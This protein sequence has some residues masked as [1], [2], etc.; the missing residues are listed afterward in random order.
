MKDST[1]TN[2]LKI[3]DENLD[4]LVLTYKES[5]SVSIE[6]NTSSNISLTT[7]KISNKHNEKESNLIKKH[8]STKVRANS[9]TQKSSKCKLGTTLFSTSASVRLCDK[10]NTKSTFQ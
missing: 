10:G 8:S 2:K 3:S 7:T 4:S 5:S 9:K 1:K 6:Y